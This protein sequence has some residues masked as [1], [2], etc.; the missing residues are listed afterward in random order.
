MTNEGAVSEP[1]GAGVVE[2]EERVGESVV[3]GL[4]SLGHEVLPI[5]E[6]AH[7]SSA[8]L[9]AQLPNGTYALGSDPRCDGLAAGI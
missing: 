4:R 8:Q 2:I 3:S 7:G 6:W 9:L 5:G 1:V